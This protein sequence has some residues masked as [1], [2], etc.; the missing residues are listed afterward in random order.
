MASDRASAPP[1]GARAGALR[2]LGGMTPGRRWAIVGLIIFSVMLSQFE[3]QTLSAL[4][5]TVTRALHFS[6]VQYGL[7]AAA[8]SIAYIVSAP[9]AARIMDG[10]GARIGM[11]VAVGVWSVA[12]GLHALAPSFGAL[13]ALRMMLGA[14]E[15]PTVPG[16]TQVLT[17]ILPPH[18]RARA[19]G[20]MFT[21]GSLGQ[22]L[23]APLASLFAVTWGWR[24]G[25]VGTAA[26]SLMWIPLW[27]VVTRPVAKQLDAAPVRVA[28][29]ST[30]TAAPSKPIWRYRA[31]WRCA[32]LVAAF[33]PSSSLIVLWGAKLL[34]K[35]YHLTQ[36]DIGKYLWIPAVAFDVGALG[37][38]DLVSRRRKP[39]KRFRSEKMLVALAAA[40]IFAIILVPRASSI[41]VAIL[42]MGIVKIGAGGLLIL[43]ISEHVPKIPKHRASVIGAVVA[44]SQAFMFVVTSI[45]TGKTVQATHS[46]HRISLI[47]AAWIIPCVA[48]WFY[49][50]PRRV[51]VTPKVK[52]DDEASES[53]AEEGDDDDEAG[54]NA[55]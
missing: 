39:R 6:E 14:A 25:F 37:F 12:A 18:A 54:P 24:Y 19:F 52:R 27:I 55:A 1:S 49:T 50:A 2:P 42:M 8:F 20:F 21:G 36:G 41:G 40:C 7:L 30:K 38:G 16:A 13:F 17:K 5:P 35:H 33:S 4:A 48:L 28:A 44:S 51:K 9:I 15:S 45:L 47:T 22:A 23:A 11:M 53:A 10:V 29:S 31:V 26:L 34:V 43:A 46:Y 3:R 32:L